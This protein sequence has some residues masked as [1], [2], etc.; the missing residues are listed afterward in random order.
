MNASN[1]TVNLVAWSPGWDSGST[2]NQAATPAAAVTIAPHQT[3]TREYNPPGALGGII[4]SFLGLVT[5][6]IAYRNP[7]RIQ[8]VA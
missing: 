3:I 8:K 4:L 6:W 2:G 5:A 1:Q 7:A